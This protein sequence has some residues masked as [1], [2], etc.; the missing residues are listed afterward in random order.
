MDLREERASVIEAVIKMGHMP[1]GMEMFAAV[2]EEQFKFIKRALDSCDYYVLIIG[3]RYGSLTTDGLSYT[4]KEFD[5]AVSIGLKVTALIHEHP[6]R[7]PFDKSEG[8][9][10]IRELLDKFRNK[11]KANRIVKHWN[12]CK[13]LPSLA[14]LG[15]TENM[16]LYPAIGW[17][18]AN[19]V[20]NEEAFAELNELRKKNDGLKS[21][22]QMLEDELKATIPQVSDL[23][24]L[25]EG[26]ELTGSSSVAQHYNALPWKF[27]ATWGE[28]FSAIGP[29]IIEM[30]NDAL[31]HTYFNSEVKQLYSSKK[32]TGQYHWTLDERHYQTVKVQLSAL[33]LVDVTMAGTV[34]GGQALFWSLTDRGRGVLHDLRTVKSVVST[35]PDSR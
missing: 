13:D 20:A 35:S 18:R 2:D 28:L 8:D 11:V 7:L 5:Y 1:T 6:E 31:M 24:G 16:S 14:I 25:D 26:Y 17:V 33:K 3:G 22:I 10:A 12:D 23:A 29:H 15:L 32:L 27:K 19:R 30:P 9:P 4:E 34:N 21:K